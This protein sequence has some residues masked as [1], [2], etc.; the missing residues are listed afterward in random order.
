MPSFAH[1]IRPSSRRPRWPLML[2]IA[3]L[4]L[5]GCAQTPQPAPASMSAIT[6][7]ATSSGRPLVESCARPEY[8]QQARERKI[9]GT[10]TIQF[11]IS[12]EGKVLKS[13]LLQSSGDASLDQAAL[14]GL[15]KCRFSPPRTPQGNVV[16]AWTSIQYVWK[17][18]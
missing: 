13:R 2:A 16:A 8:P 11:L 14:D 15:S 17:A 7:T 5:A 3:P 4:I 6:P 10:S 1:P 18:D 12:E 9:E